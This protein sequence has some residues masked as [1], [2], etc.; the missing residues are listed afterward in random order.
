L[1]FMPSTYG[2]KLDPYN[3]PFYF[4]VRFRAFHMADKHACRAYEILGRIAAI[5]HPEAR[6]MPV[7]DAAR[8]AA[9]RCRAVARGRTG[10]SRRAAECC[11]GA[12]RTTNR[13]VVDRPIAYD[14]RATAPFTVGD[15]E[16]TIRAAA[17]PGSR[18]RSSLWRPNRIIDPR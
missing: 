13:K 6:E 15:R 1:G 18:H 4:S 12:G 16:P 17:V 5:S 11:I 14:I 7:L 9:I 3:K 8:L 10:Q 2:S